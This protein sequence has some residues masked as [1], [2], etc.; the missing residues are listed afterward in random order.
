MSKG[1][2]AA[3]E[4]AKRGFANGAGVNC[5]LYRAYR[6]HINL[7]ACNRGNIMIC[8]YAGGKPGFGTVEDTK[9]QLTIKKRREVDR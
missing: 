8:F 4:S 2:C 5:N 1:S 3:A 7:L 6:E 9:Q